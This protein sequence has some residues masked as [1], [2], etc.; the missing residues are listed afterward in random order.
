MKDSRKRRPARITRLSASN[1]SNAAHGRWIAVVDDDPGLRELIATSLELAG[2]AVRLSGS[3][4]E[5][6]EH[7]RNQRPALVITDIV[8]PLQSGYEFCQILR[9]RFGDTLPIIFI[10]GVRT[11]RFDVMAGFLLGAD[12]FIAK[13]FEPGELVVRVRRA[14]ARS[15][16][17]S[18]GALYDDH[19][20]TARETEVLG[21]LTQGL[22]QKQ[23]AAYLVI[24]STTVAT[25][26]QRIL[27]KLQ[28]HSRAEAVAWAYRTGA[29]A[30]TVG[31][32]DA[33]DEPGLRVL[34]NGTER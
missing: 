5:A 25:H 28:V 8:L 15:A 12:D 23:I 6:L 17:A 7:V 22:S 29:F 3:V 26:I 33:G 13:P 16:A 30:N 21:L 9:E 10:S 4:E 27:R 20:L 34:R 1:G 19:D 31:A 14:L 32:S 18:D 11:E 24:S 2:Y